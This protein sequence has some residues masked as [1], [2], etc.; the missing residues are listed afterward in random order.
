MVFNQSTNTSRKMWFMDEKKTYT[1]VLLLFFRIVKLCKTFN[2]Y[3]NSDVNFMKCDIKVSTD[4]FP[5]DLQSFYCIYYGNWS[6]MLIKN[7]VNIILYMYTNK[8]FI[9]IKCVAFLRALLCFRLTV[10]FKNKER[11]LKYFS[12]EIPIW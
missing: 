6:Y 1:F 12:N 3:L 5:N 4:R 8:K 7:R 2:F 10:W 11:L 9:D